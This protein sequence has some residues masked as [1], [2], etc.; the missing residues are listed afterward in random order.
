MARGN[1]QGILDKLQHEQFGAI[2]LDQRYSDTDVLELILN[3]RDIDQKT[4]VV[5]L[6][7]LRDEVVRKTLA[8]QQ[9]TTIIED[10][11]DGNNLAGRLEQIFMNL[12]GK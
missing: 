1:I 4:P 7:E 8:S 9:K 11:E 3:V 6:G 12:E 5:V 2:V 10:T